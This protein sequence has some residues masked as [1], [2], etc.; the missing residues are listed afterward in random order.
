MEDICECGTIVLRE[1][2]TVESVEEELTKIG[3]D[4]KE[5]SRLQFS[6]LLRSARILR[7]VLGL[8]GLVVMARG[9]RH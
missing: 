2:G 9:P 4:I 7:R 6:V 3:I 8:S 5:I 1:L